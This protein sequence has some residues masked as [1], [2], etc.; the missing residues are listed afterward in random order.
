MEKYYI[1]IA[2]WIVGIC[3]GLLIVCGGLISFIFRR[4]VKE[5]DRCAEKNGE[6]HIIIHKRIDEF[7]LKKN[8]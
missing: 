7:L 1:Q 2:G 3:G 8:K 4:H 6:D 5:N